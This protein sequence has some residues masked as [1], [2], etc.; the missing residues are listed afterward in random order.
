LIRNGQKDLESYGTI[1]SFNRR[2]EFSES[3][4]ILLT[5]NEFKHLM[6]KEYVLEFIIPNV[7]RFA[8]DRN[9]SIISKLIMCLQ[10]MLGSDGIETLSPIM[11][12][13]E[14]IKTRNTDLFEHLHKESRELV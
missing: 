8:S 6:K 5:I 7:L 10:E 3:D 11:T 13:I 2:R 12:A 1:R 4:M 9:Y 14:F